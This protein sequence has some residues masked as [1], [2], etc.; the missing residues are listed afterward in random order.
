MITSDEIEA[1]V[2]GSME[3]GMTHEQ[4]KNF[5]VNSH[6]TKN[7]K[8]RQVLVE[9]ERRNHDRKKVLFDIERKKI[10][11]ERLEARLEVTEDEFD[12]RMIQVDIEDGKLDFG[13]FKVT[14]TQY[15]NE[16]QCFMNWINE[17]Y[18]SLEEIEEGA[19][20][21]EEDERKY[22]VARMGK[23]AAMDVYCTGRIGIGNLD[24]IAM[25][26]E[27]DQFATLNVAMQYSGLLNAGIGKIQSQIQPELD[28][29]MMNGSAPRIPTF[30][31]IEDSLNIQL[32]DK[33]KGSNNGHKSIQS[34]N[35]SEAQ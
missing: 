21:N 27:E 26:R 5:V 18:D 33:L 15:D 32:F 13:K 35:Q 14:I 28:K 30:D 2:E 7:R 23:Q 24:S 22:W 34:S 29:M 6:V 17:N 19:K 16:L 31:N 3:Y 11:I 12:R 4:I 8:L 9:V 1:L 10:E 20:V 25:M